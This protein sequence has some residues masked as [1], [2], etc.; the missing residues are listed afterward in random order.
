MNQKCEGKPYLS[1]G[2][3]DVEEVTQ[4]LHQIEPALWQRYD[5]RTKF[6]S[7]THKSTHTIPLYWLI[8]SW[9]AHTPA[10]IYRFTDGTSF[11]PWIERLHQH[12]IQQG[13][14]DGIVVKAMFAKLLPNQIIPTHVDVGNALQLAHR[15][16]WVISSH[17]AVQMTVNGES[18]HWPNHHVYEL[19]NIV[20]HSV[21]NPTDTER[22]HFIMDVMPRALL[23]AGITYQEVSWADYP[24]VE[25]IL[26]S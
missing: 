14:E 18:T 3:L 15:Y 5:F 19:N 24:S 17:S 21:E 8:N 13:I 22:I 9:R 7:L 2:E 10:T 4:E 12:L 11:F 20:K 16:H 1:Y 25:S 23:S 6:S 26:L